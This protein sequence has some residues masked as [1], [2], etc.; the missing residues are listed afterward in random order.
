MKSFD[1]VRKLWRQR[2]FTPFRIVTDSGQRYDILGPEF[3]MVT[4]TTLAVGRRKNNNDREF[5]SVHLLGVLNVEAIESLDSQS[6][7][8]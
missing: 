8:P 7:K 5:D 4:K 6:E 2:P 3:I 1:S